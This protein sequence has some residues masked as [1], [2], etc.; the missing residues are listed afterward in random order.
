LI[1]YFENK[2]LLKKEHG[3]SFDEIESMF[4]Y[5]YEMLI[6]WLNSYTERNEA[7][8]GGKKEVLKLNKNN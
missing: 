5:E 6:Q 4:Y 8:S 7:E 3:F 2:N 1:G